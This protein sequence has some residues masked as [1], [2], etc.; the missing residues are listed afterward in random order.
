MRKNYF[1]SFFNTNF[2]SASNQLSVLKNYSAI[3][4][5]SLFLLTNTASAQTTLVDP[6][7][8]GGFELGTSFAANGWSPIVSATLTTNQFTVNTGATSPYG[9]RSCYVTNSAGS[10]PPPFTYTNTAARRTS[11]IYRDV[12][13]PAGQTIITLNFNW[14]GS[15][16]PGLDRLR[17]WATPTTFTPTL[18]V[19]ITAVGGNTNIG[20]PEYVNQPAWGAAAPIPLATGLAGTT[21]RLIFEW[22]GI[23]VGVPTIPIA[24]DS[25]GLTCDYG[26][27]DDC[28]SARTLTVSSTCTVATFDTS[29]ATDSNLVM[30]PVPPA[31]GCGSYGA[32]N[33]CFEPNILI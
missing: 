30:S 1:L 22:D 15:G 10:I 28:I 2:N 7:A 14:K 23:G 21:F 33:S 29:A 32:S 5:L 12:T 20:L 16:D 4:A 9:V 27:N 3:I 31:P 8:A 26:L 19:Q 25:I 18:G 11:C 17:V 6:A 13:V 24:I